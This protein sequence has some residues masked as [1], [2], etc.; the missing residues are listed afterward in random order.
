MGG[1]LGSAAE[2]FLEVVKQGRSFSAREPH[3]CFL[4]LR[5]GSFC[6]VSAVSG[7]DLPDDG[8]GVARA[9]W[10]RDGD[11]DFL[12]SNR[13]APRL[14]FFRNDLPGRNGFIAIRLE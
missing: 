4:N 13:S 1:G 7:L 6:D 12:V 14:R 11:L 2:S 9:D 3:H 5:N 8:R 10:D